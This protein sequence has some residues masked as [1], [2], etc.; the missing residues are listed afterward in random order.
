MSTHSNIPEDVAALISAHALGVLEPDQAALAERA[1]RRERRL[2]PRLRGRARDGGGARAGRGRQR[3]AGRPARAH[4]RGRAGRAH[5]VRARARRAPA[6]APPLA[7]RRPA[8]AVG[9]LRASLGVAAAI[10]FALV[11]VSQHDSADERARPRGGA[12]RPSSRAPD[13]RVVPMPPSGGGAAGGRVDRRAA[14]APRS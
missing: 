9:R 1:H 2:P 10:V 4:R 6:P 3:A 14:A 7:P 5:R 8:H 13:A 11:A 12:R